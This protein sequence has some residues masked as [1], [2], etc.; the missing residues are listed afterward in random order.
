MKRQRHGSWRQQGG[1]LARPLRSGIVPTCGLAFPQSPSPP[2]SGRESQGG[3][4]S[5]CY[6]DVFFF[7]GEKY[8]S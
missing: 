4:M 6:R 2:G 5:D 7:P 8:W 1:T 3:V